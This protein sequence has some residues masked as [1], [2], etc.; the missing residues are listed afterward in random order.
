MWM[1]NLISRDNKELD[2]SKMKEVG[3]PV[4]MTPMMWFALVVS[5]LTATPSWLFLLAMS[6]MATD[7]GTSWALLILLFLF[8]VVPPSIL[9]IGITIGKNRNNVM[10]F[11]LPHIIFYTIYFIVM[12]ILVF[13]KSRPHTIT[14]K[15][16]SGGNVQL[17]KIT[18]DGKGN[19]TRVITTNGVITSY[20]TSTPDW[21][22]R[23]DV[24]SGLT[25]TVDRLGLKK[26]PKTE[27]MTISD[28]NGSTTVIITEYPLLT[29]GEINTGSKKQTTIYSNGSTSIFIWKSSGEYST[30]TEIDVYGSSTVKEFYRGRVITN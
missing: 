25:T 13:N 6:V 30:S 2:V 18:Y 8:F 10:W 24:E 3:V 28:Q 9:F 4:R 29:K 27:K 23:T 16:T 26:E 7:G 22:T 17:T 21:F 15:G 20:V 19:D 11:F 14:S 1:D 12:L 5:L